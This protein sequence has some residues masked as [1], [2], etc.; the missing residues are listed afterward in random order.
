MIPSR[1]LYSLAAVCMAAGAIGS[2][3]LAPFFMR[4]KGFSIAVVGMPL[5]VNGIGALCS[6]VISGTLASYFRSTFLLLA[7]VSI[8]IVTSLLGHVFQE[9]LTVFL[10]AFSVLG[11]TEAMFSLAIRRIVFAQSTADQQGRAQ[12]Q[13]AA[14]LGIGFALGPTVGGFVG[15]WWGPDKL[16]LVY[17]VPQSI[18]LVLILLARGHRVEKPVERG[19]MPLWRVGTNLLGNGAFLA[20]C[21]AMF[22]SFLF[23]IGVTRLGFPFL[24]VRRGLSLDLI[25]PMVSAS[26]LTDTLGRLGAGWLCDRI[27][28]R[29]V[30]LL[31]VFLTVPAFVLQVLG[32]GLLALLIPLCLMTA[33]FG[34]SNVGATTFALQAANDSSKG[35]A[36]GLVR[37]ATSMGRMFGPLLAGFLV[38]SIGF[39]WGFVHMALIST[40]IGLA[41]WMLFRRNADEVS[42]L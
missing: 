10:V 26:R 32:E 24:A 37:A 12:G 17:A 5:V 22:Q 40:V 29:R 31:G 8:A 28:T 7:A 38:G 30:I 25:G 18:G 3:I 21:L 34:F 13:V 35:V 39:E 1:H 20:A 15:E 2:G 19:G 23:L 9:S 42:G 27:G 36:L 16:F 11:L 33:G 41:V 4:E 6:D 14:A